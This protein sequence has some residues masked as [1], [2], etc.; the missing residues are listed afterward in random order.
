[1]REPVNIH[2][3]LQYIIKY[4]QEFFKALSLPSATRDCFCKS[5]LDY[6]LVHL[7]K[8][9]DI[10]VVLCAR[11]TEIDLWPIL[12]HSCRA[13]LAFYCNRPLTFHLS[14]RTVHR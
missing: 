5:A 3:M 14:G 6:N 7:L 13:N 9:Q 12:D 4:V 11:L 2:Y 8:P 10:L 1:M